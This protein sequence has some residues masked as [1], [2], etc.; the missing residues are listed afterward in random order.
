MTIRSTVLAVLLTA[1]TATAQAPAPTSSP[2]TTPP[3]TV[4][5]PVTPQV[6]PPLP[7]APV[8]LDRASYALEPLRF[9]GSPGSLTPEQ[10]AEVARAV[11]AELPAALTRR[12]PNATVSS[13]PDSAAV[14]LTPVVVVPSLLGLFSSLEVRFEL[15]VPGE[16]A[17]RVVSQRFGLAALWSAQQNAHRVA[18]DTIFSAL[19]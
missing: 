7:G 8:V 12:Y 2:S 18:L 5:P 13:T 19:P 6:T 15:L 10:L 4:G 16:A 9:E 3:R 11:S 1:T 14:R 17:P